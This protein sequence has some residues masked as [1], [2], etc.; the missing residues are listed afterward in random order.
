MQ[1][2]QLYL[3]GI[4]MKVPAGPLQKLTSDDLFQNWQ[5]HHPRA[6][7]SHY[8]GQLNSQLKMLSCWE[9][10]YYDPASEKI[11]VFVIN[12]QIEIKPEDEVFRQEQSAVEKLELKRVK[13]ELE[14]AEKIFQE[15]F[16]QCFPQASLGDGFLILQCLQGKTVWNFTFIDQR[17]KFL[18]LKINAESGAVEEHQEIKLVQD[19]KK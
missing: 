5:Q 13:I 15:N 2:V 8:F 11:T 14:E 16:F 3:E 17:L 4:C 19:N 9:L 12:Q 18:N 1:Q 6:F 10:G 7:L